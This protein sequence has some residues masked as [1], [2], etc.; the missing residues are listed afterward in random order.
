MYRAV[1]IDLILN[2]FFIICPSGFLNQRYMVFT[3][4]LETSL[5]V[6]LLGSV[7]ACLDA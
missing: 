3:M 5:M 2:K 4:I 7:E 6:Y 1:L